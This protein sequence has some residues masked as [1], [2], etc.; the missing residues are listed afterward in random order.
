[1]FAAYCKMIAKVATAR[2]DINDAKL[3]GPSSLGER[4]GKPAHSVIKVHQTSIGA[5]D[6]NRMLE[7]KNVR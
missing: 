3:R 2:N 5:D 7:R 1:M 4:F 6:D